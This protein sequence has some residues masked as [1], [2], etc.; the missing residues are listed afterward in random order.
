MSR[1]SDILKKIKESEQEIENLEKRRGRSQ[2]A[3]LEA[4]VIGE[5]PNETDVEYFKTYTKLIDL[6]RQNLRKLKAELEN[7]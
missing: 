6:E 2:S 3:L 7:L 5:K 4:V 1:K